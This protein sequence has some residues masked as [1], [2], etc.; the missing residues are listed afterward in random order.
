LLYKGV[1]SFS[2]QQ[3]TGYYIHFCPVGGI[4]SILPAIA[5]VGIG[6]IPGGQDDFGTKL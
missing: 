5:Q 6:A 4:F 2:N 1:F 3:Y